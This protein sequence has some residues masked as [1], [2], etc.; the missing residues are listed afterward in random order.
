MKQLIV[1]C[2]GMILGFTVQAQGSTEDVAPYKKDPTIPAF[3]IQLVDSSWYTREQL[4]TQYAHTIIIYFSPE[5]GHCQH[6]A[7]EI[8]QHMDSLKNTF[9]LFV[10]Y[11][12][13]E[14]VKG[15]AAYYGLDKLANVRIGRDPKYFIPSFYRVKYTPFLAV[16]NQKGLLEKIY[17]TENTPLPETSELIAFVNRN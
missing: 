15:F 7:K 17:D 14:D 4:P 13:L 16:Y 5:C 1:F 3:N 9:F 12:P 11:K 10:A 2:I 8:V 6:E